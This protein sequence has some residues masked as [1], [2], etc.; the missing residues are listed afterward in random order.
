MSGI[1]YELQ[2][3]R[4]TSRALVQYYLDRIALHDPLLHS[5]IELNPDALAIADAKD[6]ERALSPGKMLSPVHGI[7]ILVKD[8]IGTRDKMNTTAGSLA[9]VGSVVARD[10]SVVAGLRA[11]GMILLGKANMNEWAGI[12]ATDKVIGWSARGGTI[13]V[14][15]APSHHIYTYTTKNLGIIVYPPRPGSRIRTF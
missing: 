1:Q 14:R 4:L 13:K 8:N 2:S 9:L 7:P 11:A 6:K 3:G 10:S 15:L 12:R 5:I